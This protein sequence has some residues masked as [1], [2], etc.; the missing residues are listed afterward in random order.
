M[1]RC[2]WPAAAPAGD[3]E[4]IYHLLIAV[5]PTF[6]DL[7]GYMRKHLEARVGSTQMQDFYLHFMSKVFNLHAVLCVWDPTELV[8]K[9]S[10]DE[11]EVQKNLI[12]VLHKLESRFLSWKSTEGIS[13]CKRLGLEHRN[14][15]SYPKLR[16]LRAAILRDYDK[17]DKITEEFVGGLVAIIR[18]HNR[19]V[20]KQEQLLQVLDQAI[21]FFHNLLPAGVEVDSSCP[22]RFTDYPM[23]HLWKLTTTLF[24]VIQ[25]NWHCQCLS[26]TSHVGRQTRLNLTHHQR[27]EM[28]PTKGQ[29]I[30]SNGALFRILFPTTNSHDDEWQDTEI[31]IKHQDRER[32]EH[33]K[34]E[35]G[36]CRV[37]QGVKAGI[38][39][40]M[41]VFGETLWQLQADPD[42]NRLSQVRDSEFKSLKDLL[43]PNRDSRKS[44][45]SSIEK[46][47]R[48]I[49]S[50]ILATS[51]AHFV[52]GPWLQTG[53]N[54]ENI[55][56]L[57]SHSRS[58]PNITKPYL[59]TS[60]FSS[61][62]RESPRE[63]NQPHRFPD[64]LSL[65]I[66]L[67]EIA[68]GFAIDFKESEDRCVV[69]LHFMDK[70][71]DRS[72]TV[73]DGL[74]RAISACI[75]PAEFRNNGLD[76]PS[77]NDLDIRKY[78]FERIL[79]PLE[80]ALSTAYDIHSNTLHMD[81]LG[82]EKA[83]GVGSFD[84]HDENRQE[85]QRVAMQWTRSLEDVYDMVYECKYRYEQRSGIDQKTVRVKI[86]VLDTGLQLPGGLRENYEEAERVNMQQSD[87]FVTPTKGA[88]IHD[89]KVDD[90]GHGSRVSQILLKFAPTAELHIAKVFKTRLDL[91]DHKLATQVHKRIAEAINRA[92]NEWEVDIVVMCFGFDDRIGVI[93]DA[94]DEAL[95]AKKPP[96]FFA[97]TRNNGAHKL[98]A[99]P[100]KSRS[101]I[102]I[103]STDGNG[104]ASSFNPAAKDADPV[105]YAFGEGVPVEVSV[106]GNLDEY[107][108]TYVSGTSYATPVAA[109]L[110]ANLLG[111]VRMVVATS[112]QEDQTKYNY[113]LMDLQRLD[114]MLAVLR[115]RMQKEHNCGTK[116]LL[117]W[118]F[119]N[120]RLL[121]DNKILKDI[122]E[123]LGKSKV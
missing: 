34:V 106:P 80:D 3:L 35:D 120:V 91:E 33:R 116:S 27:F 63:L 96:L 23:K 79:Y 37:I 83:S 95:K 8:Q 111:C 64:I 12:R 104:D 84:H 87:T 54:S 89:W 112:A 13:A 65:G 55:C 51:L 31:A 40:R 48:L 20:N 57:M 118:E 32:A 105:I 21:D 121:D 72:R 86:A 93:R 88:A 77:V 5:L 102:R 18:I 92:T 123:T 42:I 94:L 117:P 75:D 74:C 114:G 9:L 16:A 10:T 108:T 50:L 17:Q 122:A 107:M 58:S 30:S 11:V 1:L 53:F 71:T 113:I 82:E 61:M 110:A 46:K 115:H 41:I 99:W 19:N 39:P 26:S 69:A 49:L 60:Y 98:M 15:D 7:A 47:D 101:V 90:D 85:K 81:I 38:R 2:I 28:A 22:I 76:K 52:R 66:L 109:A 36:L 73:P 25:K 24:N 100:A 103:S 70:W 6:F 62:Q 67:L 44:P 43:Q 14:D 97:A 78:I 4:N 29:V 59:T 68:R 45:L 119:L 56:F